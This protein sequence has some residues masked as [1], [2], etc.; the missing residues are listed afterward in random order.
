MTKKEFINE[1]EKKM[2]GLPK[3]DIRDRLL[4]YNEMIDDYI[5]DGLTEE[6]AI[7]KIGSSDEIVSK[8]IK[9]TSLTKIVKEHVKP[10]RK[11]EAWEIILIVLTFPFWFPVLILILTLILVAVVLLWSMVIVGWSV[12]GSLVGAS[13]SALFN[14]IELLSDGN[15]VNSVGSFGFTLFLAGA[16]IFLFFGA[17]WVTSQTA[18]LTK[19]VIQKI[20]LIIINRGK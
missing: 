1:L 4:F 19:K 18:E 13:I 6:E 11:L 9:E 15:F 8:L 12:F 2:K 16:T 3:E 14:T 20:K 5:E 10:K 17:V 7:S